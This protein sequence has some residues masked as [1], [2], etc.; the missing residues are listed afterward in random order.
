MEGFGRGEMRQCLALGKE[1]EPPVWGAG[2]TEDGS[3][4]Q[5]LQGVL[6]TPTPGTPKVLPASTLDSSTSRLGLESRPQPREQGSP[7]T[8]PCFGDGPRP[9][10]EA[11]LL[12]AEALTNPDST[13]ASGTELSGRDQRTACRCP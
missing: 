12:S 4:P 1:G 10:R 9:A 2:D 13:R 6:S 3:R 8:A 7:R 5:L 11:C